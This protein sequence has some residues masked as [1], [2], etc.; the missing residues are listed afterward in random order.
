MRTYITIL[1]WLLFS[2]AYSQSWERIIGNPN[3][4]EAL[5]N[6]NESYD[7]G[8]YVLG[9]KQFYP[10]TK[11]Y[12]IKTDINGYPLYEITLGIDTTQGSLP[13][14]IETTSDGG[15]I[16]CSHLINWWS[17]EV[18]VVKLNACGDLDWCNIWK[19]DNLTDWGKEIHQLDD[20]GYIMLIQQNNAD[21]TSVFLYRM[22]SYGNPLW[23]QP[24]INLSQY[25]VNSCW[26]SD[27]LITEQNKFLLSG[28]CYWCDS[29]GLC[30][31]KAVVLQTDTT[32][33][34]Q[35]VSVF[36]S[37]DPD[38][39][40]AAYSAAQL[41]GNNYYIGASK[42]I[43]TPDGILYPP[44]L[45]V[46]DTAGNFIFHALPQIPNIGPDYVRGYLMDI[47][48]DTAGRIFAHTDMISNQNDYIGKFSL[49]ELDTMGGWHN[50]F[51]HP[52]AQS[53]RSKT[54]LTSDEKILAGSVVGATAQQQDL[55]LMKFNTSLQY[56]SIYIIPRDY[57]YLCPDSI[58]SK[59]IDLDCDIIVDVKDIPTKEEYYNSIKQIPITPAP[60][61]ARDEVKFMLKNTEYHRNIRIVCYNI[62]G[63]EM[64]SVPVNAGTDEAE[65]NV[66]SWT[67]GMYVA[68][69][70]AG[71]KRVGSA[72]FIVQ[73]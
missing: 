73:N 17:D 39:Y 42:I 13:H 59:T 40:T 10:E 7:Q 19:T 47:E 48:F 25:P 33:I 27:I 61:P 4:P 56:D 20:G 2:S 36:M 32:R 1:F 51:L 46:M 45:I 66:S 21:S 69:V 23:A 8:Y 5:Q 64:G 58:V 72:R 50:T 62:F 43:Q 55:I 68:V 37:E 49:H 53:Y 52:S 41:N 44:L 63:R 14:Y 15:V 24:Y 38:F 16:I 31:L 12:F 22:D 34:E 60:N 11:G 3:R 9:I 65:M 26:M 67:S 30:R 35:W 18:S 71:N 57:D 29:T 54:I 6:I 70:Y 28:D